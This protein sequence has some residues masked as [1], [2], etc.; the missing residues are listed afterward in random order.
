MKKK[1]VAS[2]MVMVLAATTLAGCGGSSS[3]ASS[4]S[5]SADSS[6]AASS[7][8]ETYN[9]KMSLSST[10][11]D[12]DSYDTAQA[13]ADEVYAQTDGQV[14]ITLYGGGS[15]GTTSEVL[16]GLSY[17]VA[18]MLCESV[19]TL[20]TFTPLANIDAMP[21][22]FSDY[23][24]FIT[25]WYSE[26]GT[27][28]KDTIGEAGGFK[29][30]GGAFRSPRIVT[31]TY[32]METIEDFKG[33]KLRAPGLDMYMKT[34][35]WMNAT[36]TPLAITEVYTA[37]QQGTVDGQENPIGLSA[38]YAFD[39]VCKYWI[40]TYHVYSCNVIIMDDDF[41]ADLPADIQAAMV[42]AAEI[43]GLAI[44]EEIAANAESVQAE[45]EAE[46]ITFIDVDTDAFVEYFDGFADENFPE[47]TDWANQ[48]KALAE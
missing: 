28:M 24:H 44:S 4:D 29:I 15:L 5:S 16:E 48:I 13:F 46:G 43:S 12:S 30:I 9:F 2:M 11:G 14:T 8:G 1:L 38:N 23:D 21:Y 19:G 45:L 42:E 27:E 20:A 10:A 47:L 41:F 33:F 6:A 26:I 18:D 40:N 25:T 34:W 32:P 35:E 31:S 37:L 3:T 17:G 36:P 39:E 7:E 22:L